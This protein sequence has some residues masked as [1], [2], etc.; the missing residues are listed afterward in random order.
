MLP[1]ARLLTIH[2]QETHDV[3]FQLLA[4]R[5]AMYECLVDGCPLKLKS[6]RERKAHL[7]AEH[8]YPAGFNFGAVLGKVNGRRKEK[9]GGRSRG[10]EAGEKATLAAV[11]S[12]AMEAEDALDAEGYSKRNEDAAAAAAGVDELVMMVGGGGMD[13]DVKD[14]VQVQAA[15]VA[16]AEPEINRNIPAVFSFGRG[17]GGRM[18]G[19]VRGAGRR[20]GGR[21]GGRGPKT[22]FHCKL[23]GHVKRECPTHHADSGVGRRGGGGGGG[24]TIAAKSTTAGPAA[25]AASGGGGG[26]GDG[27][28]GGMDAA[29]D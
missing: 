9:H 26:G 24:S 15:A 7:I 20:G 1:S 29:P 17:R 2:I 4:E 6:R 21:G 5:Q 28:A 25:A 13:V 12:T 11:S 16:A 22:C 23:P 3:M 27:T 19:R 14:A 8:D 10:K 18:R